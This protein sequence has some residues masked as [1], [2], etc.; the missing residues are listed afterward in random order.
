MTILDSTN[1]NRFFEGYLTVEMK[2]KQGEITMVD[3]LYKVL[4]IWMDRGAPITDTHSNRVIGKGIN[5]AKSSVESEGVTYPA[6]KITGKIHKNYELDTDIWDKIRTGEYRGLSFGGATK[7]DRTPKVMKDGDIAYALTD[8]E[9]YEVAV[10]KDPAVPLAIITDYNP[11][12][13]A[14]VPS[15]PRGD[16]KEVIKCDKFGCYVDKEITDKDVE[17]FKSQNQGESVKYPNSK[18]SDNK[19]I[20]HHRVGGSETPWK[21]S[22]NANRHYR[23]NDSGDKVEKGGEDWSNADGTTPAT[24]TNTVSQSTQIAK[25]VKIDTKVGEIKDGIKTEVTPLEGGLKKEGS[26]TAMSGTG[27]GVRAHPQDAYNQDDGEKQ[28]NQNTTTIIQIN[29]SMKH[30]EDIN[31]VLGAIAAGAAR[32]GASITS[33][34]VGGAADETKEFVKDEVEENVKPLEPKEASAARIEKKE[35]WDKEEDARSKRDQ[36]IDDAAFTHAGEEAEALVEGTKQTRDEDRAVRSGKVAPS[37]ALTAR[38]DPKNPETVEPKHEVYLQLLDELKSGYET[39]GADMTLGGQAVPKEKEK[40]KKECSQCGQPFDDEYKYYE[41]QVSNHKQHHKDSPNRASHNVS[42]ADVTF[43]DNNEGNTVA[44]DTR[45]SKA[46]KVP[47]KKQYKTDKEKIDWKGYTNPERKNTVGLKWTEGIGKAWEILLENKG[48]KD[49]LRKLVTPP[50]I[51][52][53]EI[54][55]VDESTSDP[56]SQIYHKYDEDGI[57]WSKMKAWEVFLDK[58]HEWDHL[59]KNP[60]EDKKIQEEIDDSGNN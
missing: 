28:T 1:E 9:H 25:P 38:G 42:D 14:T 56:D 41:D 46:A 19:K 15:E 26:S 53:S 39:T 11:L 21:R 13:K 12:A 48:V 17:W 23:A 55:H 16:G 4:P 54:K 45:R 51:Y 44:W 60:E 37:R 34:V 36:R 20:I 59:S 33:G 50:D 43:V 24:V 29:Q 40:A 2:D 7:A 30:N 32:A 18:R 27:G 35:S 3:E 6:I 31:K 8:L 22:P 47:Q 49:K 57:T 5:F 58:K 52:P 10:C